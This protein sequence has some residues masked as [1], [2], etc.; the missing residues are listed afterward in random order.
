MI[1]DLPYTRWGF[2]TR[3][4]V[5][6]PGDG[7]AFAHLHEVGHCGSL[8]EEVVDLDFSEM[9]GFFAELALYWTTLVDMEPYAQRLEALLDE[10]DVQFIA[11]THGLP[12]GDVKRI[13]PH[14]RAGLVASGRRT[15]TSG[16]VGN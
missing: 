16:F 4:R 10:L 5:L 6:F 13:F 1:R 2:D 15:A 3:R 8:A 9:S 7:F 14:I 11:P 12:I